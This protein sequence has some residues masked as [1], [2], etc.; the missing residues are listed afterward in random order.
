MV[1]DLPPDE[2]IV[3]QLGR[4][5]PRKG[6]DNVIRALAKLNYETHP[7]RLLIVGGETDDADLSKN[8]E[9]VRLLD[10]AAQERVTAQVT[11]TGRKNRDILK[12][13]YA[14]ADIFI[15]TPWYEPF[16]ITPLEAMACGTPVIGSDVGGIKYSVADGKTGFLVPPE[17]PDRLAEKITELLDN[18]SLRAKMRENA[19]LHVN[20]F[21]TWTRV[22]QMM[23]AVYERLTEPDFDNEEQDHHLIK[24][25]FDEAVHTLQK[26]KKILTTGIREAALL[27]TNC[28]KKNKK[29]LICGNGGSA[30]ETQHL[31]AELVG[32]F[33][34]AERKAL[35]AI[36]L[37]ADSSIVTA[38]AN[39]FGYDDIF[40]RQVDAYGE[41]GDVLFCFSTSGESSNVI[42]AMQTANAR[43]M[44]CIAVTGKGGGEMVSY[45]HV[46]IV[47]PSTNTQRIQEL[48][49]HILH[50]ICSLVEMKLFSRMSP[51]SEVYRINGHSLHSNGN[52]KGPKNF[53]LQNE[54]S[55]FH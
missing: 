55:S 49:L 14:A 38:W 41:N 30:A 48:H 20:S 36:S 3:L 23:H 31:A 4:M 25:A 16:G 43:G 51:V 42:K 21:F 24:T 26:S 10:I 45:A 12:Y 52:G 2:K 15:T 39:D 50:T 53:H 32:R 46:N 37:T 29:V 17:D 13:Y 8:Q 28:F 5:V 19:I 44:L 9:L 1:L 27:L 18:P 34:V 22:A 6:V 33:E 40:A 54:Q 7:V 11:F 35:P 47:V